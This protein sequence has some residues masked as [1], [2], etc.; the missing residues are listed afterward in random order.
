MVYITHGSVLL[1]KAIQ[2]IDPGFWDKEKKKKLEKQR[3]YIEKEKSTILEFKVGYYYLDFTNNPDGGDLKRFKG[4]ESGVFI[5]GDVKKGEIRVQLKNE[6]IITT[7]AESIS[8][9]TPEEIEE[10]VKLIFGG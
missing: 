4:T 1:L 3:V 7:K 9:F 8:N 10:K 6:H 5:E 2:K